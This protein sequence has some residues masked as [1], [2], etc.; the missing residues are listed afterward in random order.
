MSFQLASVNRQF[1]TESES[2]QRSFNL[3]HKG[4]PIFSHEFDGGSSTNVLIGADTFVI[5][6]HF[7]EW[8]QELQ[9]GF[10]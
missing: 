6:N 9:A 10:A 4:D 7:Q 5:K 2:F 8:P 3:T 1:N